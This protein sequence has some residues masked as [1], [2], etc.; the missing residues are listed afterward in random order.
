MRRWA[1]LAALLLAS[2]HSEGSPP[3]IEVED[4]WARA[5]LPGQASSA[6]YLTVANAGGGDRLLAVS[7]PS[8]AASLHSTSMDN[9]VM[10]MRPV[11][12]LDVPAQSTVSL[13]PGGTHVMLTGLK[14]PLAEGSTIELDLR[15]EK[16]GERRV[17]AEVRAANGGRM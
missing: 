11:E 5:T 6:A 8:A 16:S 12:R 17:A 2:C 3:K 10:R 15:F 7:S 13:E 14:Q 9:G 1:A 4:A